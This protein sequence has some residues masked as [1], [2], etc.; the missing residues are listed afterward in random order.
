[1]S[2]AGEKIGDLFESSAIIF[3]GLIIGNALALVAEALI[4]RSLSPGA[5]GSIALA[6]T[7][8]L[9]GGRIAIFG[10]KD[11]VV[12]LISAK[13]AI[14]ERAHIIQHGL[15]IVLLTGCVVGIG[16]VASRD[17]V[18]EIV[19]DPLVG[20]YLLF[21][22]PFV[23]FFS[24][25]A[26]LF[27]TLRAEERS[28]SAVISRDILGRILPFIILAIAIFINRPILGAVG[29]WLGVPVAILLSSLL[30]L[31][32]RYPLS[33]IILRN[34]N[35]DTFERLL[36]FSLPLAMGAYLSIFL[37]HSD[38]LMIGYFLDSNEVGYYRA[39]QPLQQASILLLM[40][41]SFL[42]LPAATQFYEQKEIDDLERF[43]TVST[44]WISVGTLPIV[45]VFG[46]FADDV[47]RVLFGAA[48]SPAAPALTL[49]V[50]GHFLRAVVGLNGDIVKA[51]DRTK[52]ELI[53]VLIGVITNILLNIYLIPRVGIVGAA[54]GT[55]TGFL[56]YNI[57]ELFAIYRTIEIHPFAVNNFKPLVL[58]TILALVI[59]GF[60]QEIRFGIF[61]LGALG[62][63]FGIVA[64]VS[65]VLTKSIDKTDLILLKRIEERTGSDLSFIK[66]IF[67]E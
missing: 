62:I 64:L 7:V 53:S 13:S 19:E 43:Y 20:R 39:V 32:D 12:R 59:R 18:A 61:G 11:G 8:A 25:R 4:A 55:A 36:R 16:F 5:Y 29:Y 63:L 9:L 49:L 50:S 14:S 21:F 23:I 57:T 42:F 17:I 34:P 65:M 47:V 22:S 44:K 27:G 28:V 48:Y 10:I 56:A 67:N 2:D 35:R 24:A 6:Y 58:T 26:V 33:E 30:F 3:I 66:F 37:T 46:L 51:I 1:M 31:R 45:L 38:I 41:F 40:A 52:I 60:T 54:I 15:A